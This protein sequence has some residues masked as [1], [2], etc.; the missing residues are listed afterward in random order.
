MARAQFSGLPV[1]QLD[2]LDIS[3][4]E[5]RRQAIIEVFHP[6]LQALGEELLDILQPS[7]GTDLHLFQPRLNWP[8]SYKPFCTWLAIS[9]ETQGYQSC[10]QLNVGVHRDHVAVRLGFDT[11]VP[12]YGR[13][14]FLCRFH[15]LGDRLKE[16]ATAHTLEFRVYAAAPW[17]EGSRMVFDSDHDLT[18]AFED[19]RLHGVWFE[20]GRRYEL[21]N[22]ADLVGDRRFLEKVVEVFEPLMPVYLEAAGRPRS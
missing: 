19:V 1:H 22:H 7:A 20:I 13:F 16:L 5:Q 18:G 4:I 21:P 6:P 11:S 8:R 14:E 17:P 10:G 9:R 12:A 3:D 15:G 2:V